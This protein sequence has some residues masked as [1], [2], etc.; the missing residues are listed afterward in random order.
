MSWVTTTLTWYFYLLAIGIV[1]FPLAIRIFGQFFDKGYPFAK[2]I[3]IIVLSYTLFVLG[4]I[5]VIPFSQESIVFLLI[6]CVFIFYSY[7]RSELVSLRNLSRKKILIIVAE[8]LLFLSAFL[9]LAMIRSLEPSIRGLEKFMDF[10][11]MQSIDRTKYFPPIDMWLSADATNPNG[12]PINYYYFGHLTGALLTKLTGIIPAIGYNLILAT[13]F[14]QG[15]TLAFSLTANIAYTIQYLVRK[16]PIKPFL[17]IL[18]GLL[19][20]FLIN[21]AGN[22]HTIYIFTTGYPNEHPEPYWGIFQS[23]L[24][25]VS[26]LKTN[27]GQLLD[28]LIA[29]SS[30]WYPNATRFI[31][32]TIHEFPSYSYVVSDLHGHVFDIPFVLLTLAALFMFLTQ[33]Y[34]EVPRGK[35]SFLKRI[36]NG[37]VLRFQK[38]IKWRKKTALKIGLNY[39]EV[40]IAIGLGF[41]IAVH[42]MT[43]AFDGP[44]YLLL[45]FLIFYL[46]YSFSLNLL[47]QA[48]IVIVSFIIFSLPFSSSFTPFAT[49]IGVNCS[50]SFL[51][52]IEKFGPFLFEKGNCQQSVLWMIGVLWGFFWITALLYISHLLIKILTTKIM[53][54]SFV[55]KY[56]L[57]LFAFGTFLIFIPEFFYIKDIYPAH[58][59]ANTMFKMGYQAFIMMGLAASIVIFIISTQQK[60]LAK[61]ILLTIFFP[62]FMLVF[63]YPFVAFPSY[64][65]FTKFKTFGELLKK[66]NL[67]GSVWAANEL[68]QDKEIID[69]INN[70]IPNQ[71][72][73]LEA[74]GDSYTDF[75]RIAAYTGNPT[76]AGWWVHEWLWR[77][78]ADVVGN[79]IPDIVAIYESEDIDTTK[80]LLKKY[81][82]SYV[83]ISKMEREKYKNLNEEK[84][85][86]IGSKIFESDNEF[87]A[88]YKVY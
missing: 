3:G 87:G 66:T 55:D 16:T 67:D 9:F 39:N 6:A 20:S 86:K 63:I 57:V 47:V 10:G 2:T 54:H 11:F 79:R 68:P 64:Y 35:K 77:G 46:T 49:G 85:T 51:V 4:K 62:F 70:N 83:V 69:Y 34:L 28:A 33:K 24:Q 72:V 15:V 5:R 50:P 80:S 61:S 1:F 48:L 27:G 7:F 71:P 36:W 58:F 29:N 60:R 38:I 76:V 22:L 14:A 45:T 65:P 18:T 26:A 21:L 40:L 31:P 42:Y 81:R 84:F 23:P 8:E 19:G 25:I 53:Q 12:Y 56:L 59:R 32:Y 82:V 17:I 73:I 43:N 37:L 30:Y 44:I 75:N 88:L 41:M 13:I 52:E 78:S 74:Q